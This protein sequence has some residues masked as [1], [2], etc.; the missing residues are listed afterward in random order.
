M[1][2][3]R[4]ATDI[5]TT[6]TGLRTI[7]VRFPTS[8]HL[9]GSDAM[10]PDP[11]YSAAYVI[12]ETDTGHE[13]HG[14]TFTIGR[15]NDICCAAIE[16]MRHLVVG[17]DMD[18]VAADM[19]RFWR[20]V[21]SDSQ[22]RWIGPDKGAIHL[23]T[24]AVVN[25]VWDLWARIEGKPVWRLVADMSPGELVRCIDFRYITDCITPEQALR[26]LTERAAGK[27]ER[28]ETLLRE[29][30][31]CYTTSAG[32]LGYGDDKLRDL[33]RKAVDAGFRHIKLKVGRDLDD[34]IRRLRIARE[35]VGPDVHLMIDANQVWEVGVAIEW[36]KKLAFAAP[37][38]IEEP[39]SPDDIE[40]HRKIREAI[41]PI[42]VAT[43]EMCQNRI[44]FKQLIMRGAVDVVQIDACRLGGVNEI[45][46]VMLMA[47]KYGLKVCPHAGGVG[48]CEYVQ[49]LSM[50]DYLC[51][52]GTR[53]GRV[54][55][56][57]DHLHE[58]FVDPCVIRGAAYMP[59]TAPG[60]S[61]EMKASSLKDYEFRSDRV[62]VS[63]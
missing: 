16:A 28:L 21:T 54:I 49:H 24:G 60:F 13:G 15:G 56:Y 12:L 33:C 42:Q 45:L 40:G 9:D 44:I 61:I 6:I 8:V 51:I 41:A 23:A 5:M 31:P 34:D 53:E 29:G 30:Y 14:L 52:A 36:V 27:A 43:G 59:P 39:T 35:T 32:W 62:K 10:N 11:D 1:R 17:L 48:L 18:W 63:P 4:K 25:A 22:L 26:L 38:F 3:R 20:H 57:V 58:H 55:E 50:I 7:D 46:A 37:W 19:G 47:A 2:G